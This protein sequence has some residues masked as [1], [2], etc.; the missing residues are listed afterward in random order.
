MLKIENLRKNYG[1]RTVLK[2]INLKL[3]RG[4]WALIGRNGTGKSTLLRCIMGIENYSGSVKIKNREV[5]YL[6]PR[7]IASLIGYVPQISNQSLPLTVR[8]FIEMGAYYR[9]GSVDEKIKILNILEDKKI[10]T[11][12]GGEFQKALIIRALI[13]EPPILL[14]DEP[15]SH[16]DIKN[17][18]EI[19]K[20]INDY[21]RKNIVIVVIHDLNFLNFVDGIIALKN[22]KSRILKNFEQRDLE[23]VF[24]TR[25]KIVKDGTLKFIIPSYSE[26]LIN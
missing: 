6:H 9:N 4:L 16:L 17:T 1:K 19:M 21:S 20:I 24:D 15:A 25:I 11:L 8:E 23:N 18:T 7:E 22:G 10:F 26:K 3:E 13:G 14:L 5:K 12:S 2:N